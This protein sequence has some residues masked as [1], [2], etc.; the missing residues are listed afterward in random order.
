MSCPA[1][2]QPVAKVTDSGPDI[3]YSEQPWRWAKAGG[4]TGVADVGEHNESYRQK[5]CCRFR[6]PDAQRANAARQSSPAPK[7]QDR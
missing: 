3:P 1:Y 4:G 6:T 7:G 5:E 2:Y